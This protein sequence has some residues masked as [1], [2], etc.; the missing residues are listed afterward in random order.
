MIVPGGVPGTSAADTGAGIC[1]ARA[2]LPEPDAAISA[3][4]IAMMSRRVRLLS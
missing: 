3:P 2:I 1:C 4:T